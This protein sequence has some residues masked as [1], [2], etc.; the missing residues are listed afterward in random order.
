ML[1][2][3]FSCDGVGCKNGPKNGPKEL[4]P[5]LTVYWAIRKAEELFPNPNGEKWIKVSSY[6]WKHIE[7]FRFDPRMGLMRDEVGS[8]MGYGSFL[9]IKISADLPSG[10]VEFAD[11]DFFSLH[12]AT[13]IKQRIDTFDLVT[14]MLTKG[15]ELY[16][17]M[18]WC[19]RLSHKD[20]YN[21]G[22]RVR[23]NQDPHRV[24]MNADPILQRN[25]HVAVVCGSILFTSKDLPSG[26][27]EFTDA[28]YMAIVQDQASW[29]REKLG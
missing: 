18:D 5:F 6:D 14:W 16:P 21:G 22:Y 13:W 3:S 4:L 19:A 27:V 2:T 28:G 23:M 12:T 10:E 29:I 8:C 17:N 7:S 24:D 1:F 25:E 9:K 15:D 11:S 26:M 20:W